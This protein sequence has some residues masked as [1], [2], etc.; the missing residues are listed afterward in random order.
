[1]RICPLYPSAQL[2]LLR[3]DRL[4]TGEHVVPVERVGSWVLPRASCSSCS[5]RDF[6]QIVSR[7]MYGNIRLQFWFRTPHKQRRPKSVKVD[8]HQ[9]F[10]VR[11]Q[12]VSLKQS[13]TFPVLLPTPT[14][15]CYVPSSASSRELVS[16]SI[17]IPRSGRFSK[18]SRSKNANSS[19]GGSES[20][21][22]GRQSISTHSAGSSQRS[23]TPVC[24][25][26]FGLENVRSML[27]PLIL[28]T[29][30]TYTYLGGGADFPLEGTVVI[31]RYMAHQ[32]GHLR[33]PREKIFNG[34]DPAFRHL[35]KIS[36]WVVVTEA[37]DDLLPDAAI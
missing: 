32:D 20:S 18:R 30:K 8:V 13:P 12:D 14:P 28:G 21:L 16:G 22:F 17:L 19:Q 4:T 26:Q 36:Y 6:E 3:L 9:T 37:F 11:S 10:G 31:P 25:A 23:L 15:P 1:M 27:A 7:T 34:Q 35:S 2:Y 24:I 29:S 33:L 5:T